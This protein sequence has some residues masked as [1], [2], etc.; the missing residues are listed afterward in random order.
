MSYNVKLLILIAWISV[1][2]TTTRQLVLS[3][4][5]FDTSTPVSWVQELAHFS[6]VDNIIQLLMHTN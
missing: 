4:R 5:V 2:E 3:T 6:Y 1:K